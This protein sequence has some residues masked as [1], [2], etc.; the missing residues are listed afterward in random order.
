MH[1]LQHVPLFDTFKSKDLGDSK[2][3]VLMRTMLLTELIQTPIVRQAFTRWGQQTGLSALAETYARA[4]DRL[5]KA[6]GFS[7]RFM[8]GQQGSKIDIDMLSGAIQ[9]LARR[10]EKV[11][12]QLR[13]RLL[14]LPETI[15]R[16]SLTVAKTCKT[17]YP[18]VVQG[19]RHGFLFF[20]V[21]IAEG[22][23]FTVSLTIAPTPLNVTSSTSVREFRALRAAAQQRGGRG[24][25]AIQRPGQSSAPV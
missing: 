20:I 21:A 25:R 16:D 4:S 8:L 19:L 15:L 17:P 18:F 1:R 23:E 9:R 3:Y 14:A 5:A 12:A 6:L 10:R 13:E 22:T 11:G 24:P 7:G 2:R